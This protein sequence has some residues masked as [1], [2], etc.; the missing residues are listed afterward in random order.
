[1]TTRGVRWSRAPSRLTG[2]TAGPRA[3]VRG[4]LSSSASSGLTRSPFRTP[5]PPPLVASPATPTYDE[6]EWEEPHGAEPNY[7]AAYT[8][9]PS[10]PFSE[11]IYSHLSAPNPKPSYNDGDDGYD[12]DGHAS[13]DDDYDA[14]DPQPSFDDDGDDEED[15]DDDDDDH[16]VLPPP[17]EP[18]PSLSES[19]PPDH[20]PTMLPTQAPCERACDNYSNMAPLQTVVMPTTPLD[21]LRMPAPAAAAYAESAPDPLSTSGGDSARVSTIA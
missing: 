6:D 7:F 15:D 5:C 8:F 3:T 1:M 19:E 4:T 11:S 14:P 16:V 18:T 21:R 13:F 9:D 10:D 20:D 2:A 17:I 12:D